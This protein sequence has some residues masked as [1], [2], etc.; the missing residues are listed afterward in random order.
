[1][2]KLLSIF[3]LFSSSVIIGT[4]FNSQF[5]RRKKLLIQYR[6]FI[7]KLETE[8]GYFKEPLPLILEK[9]HSGTNDPID[10]LLRQCMMHLDET[11]ASASEIW[12]RAVMSA[13]ETEPLKSAD[14]AVLS[15]CGTFLGQSDYNSQKGHFM[16]LKEE[17]SQQI[18]EAEEICRVKGPLCTKAGI[19]VGAVIAIALL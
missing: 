15:K 7:Q 18:K 16:L 4:Y 17:L 6:D 13:Y 14:L 9:L 10:I 2:F 1:M 5:L 12:H 8:I 19:S 3:L 11:T